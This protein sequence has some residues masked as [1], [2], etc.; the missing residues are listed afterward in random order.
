VHIDPTRLGASEYNILELQAL[1][2]GRLVLGFPNSGLLVWTP[3]DARGH[4]LTVRDGLPGEQI[5]R[6]SLDRMH[7]PPILFVPTDGGLAAF[8]QVPQ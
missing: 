1:P 2:D 7:N 4:R 3:G 8:R 6:M 5:R